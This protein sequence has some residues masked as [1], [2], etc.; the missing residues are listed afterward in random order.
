M[1]EVTHGSK[2]KAWGSWKSEERV[3]NRRR[4]SGWE[5]GTMER[6]SKGNVALDGGDNRAGIRS[7]R[8]YQC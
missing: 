1:V 4:A 3:F 8:R 2:L 5:I 6:A 7:I